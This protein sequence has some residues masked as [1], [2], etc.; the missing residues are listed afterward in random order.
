MAWEGRASMLCEWGT[1]IGQ[2]DWWAWLLCLKLILWLSITWQLK[3][4]AWPQHLAC[5]SGFPTHI[6]HLTY[7]PVCGREAEQP[8]HSLFSAAHTLP[9]YVFGVA[10]FLSS[11]RT[12]RRLWSV[13]SHSNAQQDLDNRTVT[14][15]YSKGG[16]GSYTNRPGWS[17]RV[18]IRTYVR[19]YICTHVCTYKIQLYIYNVF[20]YSMYPE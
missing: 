8:W 9:S 10:D 7:L 14:S 17:P 13:P 6:L 15:L 16:R 20:T 19:T 5:F 18:Y 11:A 12:D 3:A 2:Q 1:Y 4:Q